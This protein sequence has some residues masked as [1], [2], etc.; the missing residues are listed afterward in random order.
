[1]RVLTRADGPLDSTV[2]A[3][4]PMTVRHLLTLTCG[5]GAVLSATPLQ[6]EMMARGVYPGPLTPKMSGDEFVATL[7]EIPL[8]FQ[9]G[10]GWL[11]DTGIDI[12]GVL[13]ARAAG[14]PLSS[15]VASY[16]TEP[17]R[18]GST[19]F[20]AADAGRLATAYV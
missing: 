16:I 19:A 12:V 6:S 15:L 3:D 17:L 9:P 10:T 1:L 7:A 4:R 18:L 11:Y 2:P 5:W 8:A 13:L 20:W 14:Q